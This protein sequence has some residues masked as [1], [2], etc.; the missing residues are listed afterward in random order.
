MG[1]HEIKPGLGNPSR[2][3][4]L[5]GKSAA[6]VSLSVA[7]GDELIVSEDVA[8]Q[9]VA[10]DGAFKPADAEKRETWDGIYEDAEKVH[11]GE[12]AAAVAQAEASA[13]PVPEPEPVPVVKKAPAK[14][15]AVK[16][17]PAKADG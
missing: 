17:A 4:I 15:S 12:R 14:K 11:A 1:L 5:D 10:A 8:A 3:L 9:L 6:K 13:T 7:P 16:K 2:R